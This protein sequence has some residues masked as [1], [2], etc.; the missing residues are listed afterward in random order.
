VFVTSVVSLTALLQAATVVS[1][2]AFRAFG[3]SSFMWLF[4]VVD[5]RA[6]A[7]LSALGGRAL[8]LAHFEIFEANCPR[9][10]ALRVVARVAGP[11]LEVGVA[12]V[13]TL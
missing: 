4:G 1:C 8:G 12:H 2:S 9:V 13:A 11:L 3:T 6:P 10:P 7:I 5:G